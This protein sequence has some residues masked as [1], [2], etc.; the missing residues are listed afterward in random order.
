MKAHV[1]QPQRYAKMRAHTATHLLHF[2]LH[3]ILPWWTKQAWSLVDND[4][5]RFDF[6]AKQALSEKEIHTIQTHINEYIYQAIPVDVKEMSLEDA[7]KTWAK[8]F[9][10]DKYW[11][12]VRVV[13]MQEDSTQSKLVSIELCGWTHVHNTKDIGA[14]MIVSQESVAS[15]IRRIT[16]YTWTKVTEYCNELEISLKDIASAL[17]CT[18]KQIHEKLEKTLKELHHIQADHESLQWQIVCQHLKD[19]Q[20]EH[21]DTCLP[22]MCK[23]NTTNTPLEHHTFKEVINQAKQLWSD[24]DWI[25]FNE[26]WNFAIYVWSGKISAK[27][28][29]REH[30]LKWWWSDTLVQGRDTSIISI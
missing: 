6:S 10:E 19:M 5:V 14:F 8:A 7:K 16:A 15:W 28:F 12:T 18:P 23:I 24:K 17:D 9:F 27:E 3:H 1:H 20:E 30:S 11:D 2:M 22:F 29:A 13:R 21:K 25:I 26:S 4:L